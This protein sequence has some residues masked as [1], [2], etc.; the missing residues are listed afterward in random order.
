MATDVSDPNYWNELYVSQQAGWDKGTAA[1]PIARLLGERLLPPGGTLAVLG[2][3]R[4]H[5]AA[6]AAGAGYAV[7]AID[8]A[9][10]AVKA[11]R[12]RGGFTVLQAD[13]FSVAGPF[14]AALEHTCFCAIDVKRRDEYVDAVANMLK[15]DGVLFGLFYAHGRPGGPPFDTNADE[16]RERFS[17]RFHIERLLVPSDSFDNR[18]GKELEAVMRRK[19]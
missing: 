17:R 2:A 11:M 5:E 14:D 16:V 1:P 8:F 3:G 12:S 19:T 7:T 15:P 18:A 6:A 13:V 4:G 10:E 9:P